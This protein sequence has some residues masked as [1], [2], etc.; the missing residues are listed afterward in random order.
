MSSE[1]KGINFA[2]PDMLFFFLLPVVLVV[3]LHFMNYQGPRFQLKVLFTVL[4]KKKVTYILD[5]LRMSK[6]TANFHFG[7]NYHFKL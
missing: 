1:A 5:S 3:D 7:V 2:L 6:L 4:L